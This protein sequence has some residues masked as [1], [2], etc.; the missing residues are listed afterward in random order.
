V[1]AAVRSQHYGNNGNVVVQRYLVREILQSL[2]GVLAVLL[3]VFLGRHFARFLAEAA[4]GNLPAELIFRFLTTLTLSSSVLLIP[5]AFYIAVLL[6]FGR[7]Y[8]DNEMTALEAA[9]FGSA[10]AIRPVMMLSG[11]VALIV[12][13]LS[14]VVAPWAV[15]QGLK[16][17]EQAEAQSDLAGI[18]AGQFR[19]IGTE[20]HVF[21]IEQSADDGKLMK[22]VF[23]Q[24]GGEHGDQIFAAEEGYRLI[25]ETSG[26]SFLV[27]VNGTR[28]EGRP[29]TGP[30][31][32]YEY[33]KAS[34]RIEPKEVR[35]RARKRDAQ[36]TASLIRSD[37][38]RDQ[39]ELQWRVSMPVSAFLLGLLAMLVSRTSPREGRYAR[40]FGAILIYIIYN[41]L[42]GVA[43]S[44]VQNGAVS[45][46]VG[47]WWVH[48]LLAGVIVAMLAR[49]HG[50]RLLPWRRAG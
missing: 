20:N 40:L 8:R 5:F 38:R 7:L 39:A 17:K 11:V 37:D 46:A 31:R 6:A 13:G 30:F 41:N 9:G 44:W 23:V 24:G 45:P 15:E 49:Q 21:Y 28:Y 14:L 50:L 12:T 10:R 3:L 2:V 34:L 18:A 4:A 43:Q 25:D 16:L 42:M 1:L 33:E 26:D 48:L 32:I 27:L 36:P 35:R 19:E 47:M 22:H 29:G